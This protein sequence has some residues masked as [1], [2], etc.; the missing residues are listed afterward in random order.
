MSQ[1]PEAEKA[2]IPE[3]PSKDND[4][5]Y[6]PMTKEEAAFEALCCGLT[7][8]GLVADYEQFKNAIDT[9]MDALREAGLLAESPKE[10]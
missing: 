2:P 8:A 10:V 1:V 5:T 9:C 4:T 7:R 3:R 6:R